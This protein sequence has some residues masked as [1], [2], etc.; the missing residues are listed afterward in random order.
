M[1]RLRRFLSLLLGSPCDAS[2]VC[3]S[4]QIVEGSVLLGRRKRLPCTAACHLP[5]TGCFHVLVCKSDYRTNSI[6]TGPTPSGPSQLTVVSSAYRT[7]SFSWLVG[8]LFQSVY[9]TDSIRRTIW[10]YCKYLTW[11]RA[12]AGR[13]RIIGAL[14]AK[15]S[16]GVAPVP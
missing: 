15:R 12:R 11:A 10:V 16:G 14:A 9:R 8:E 3:H 13:A 6:L 4:F 7:S 5:K 2:G 1:W